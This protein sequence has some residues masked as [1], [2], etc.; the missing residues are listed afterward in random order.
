VTIEAI[1]QDWS[2]PN[3]VRLSQRSVLAQ[4][5]AREAYSFTRFVALL[6]ILLLSPSEDALQILRMV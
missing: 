5:S 6:L 4:P 1:H 2:R 3:L